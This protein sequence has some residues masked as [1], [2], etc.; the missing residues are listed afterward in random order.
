MDRRR[1]VVIQV[2]EGEPMGPSTDNRLCV[3]QWATT[4]MVWSRQRHSNIEDSICTDASN[5]ELC[6]RIKT[7]I[8][9]C[10]GSGL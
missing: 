2:G 5:L 1:N 7:K 9:D 10:V 4:V 3:R 8:F 6:Q